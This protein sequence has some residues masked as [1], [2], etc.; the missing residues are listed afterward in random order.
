M[1]TLYNS[2]NNWKQWKY[3]LLGATH[4]QAKGCDHVIVK[5]L[6]SHPKVVPT[7]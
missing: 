3:L 1:G 7:I 5:A 6:D 2:N 4:T